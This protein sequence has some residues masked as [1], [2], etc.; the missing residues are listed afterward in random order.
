[1]PDHYAPWERFARENHLLRKNFNQARE[2]V[3]KLLEEY[4]AL[5]KQNAQEVFKRRKLEKTLGY[6]LAL[7]QNKILPSKVPPPPEPVPPQRPPENDYAGEL[8]NQIAYQDSLSGL[9]FINELQPQNCLKNA[10]PHPTEN[11]LLHWIIPD[12]SPGAG[13]HQTLFRMVYGL[14]KVGYRHKIW[15]YGPSRYTSPREALT[16]I[17]QSFAQIEAEIGFINPGNASSIEGDGAIATDRWSAYFVRSI[18]RVYKRFY[19][20]QDYEPDFYASGS[21]ALL[22]RATY[23]FGFIPITAGNWLREKLSQENFIKSPHEGHSFPLGVDTR[24]YHPL[25]QKKAPGTPPRIAF[26]ARMNTPRR[27]VELGLLALERL[28]SQGKEFVVDLFGDPST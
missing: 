27:S 13:G 17:Q 12:F 15:I 14:E 2:E 25:P 19:F 10:P 8:I 20:I 1:M 9:R 28:A 24:L 7:L 23:S 16:S 3:V 22:S 26:Y 18:G 11:P 4:Q 21:E 5:A 6:R